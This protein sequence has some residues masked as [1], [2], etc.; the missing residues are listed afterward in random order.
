[1]SCL[2]SNFQ[3][4][5]EPLS[6]TCRNLVERC[7]PH[8]FGSTFS[9][10]IGREL[11]GPPASYFCCVYLR[12]LPLKYVETQKERQKQSPKQHF[13]GV[14][15]VC[16]R[17]CMVLA[18]TANNP[19]CSILSWENPQFQG[20][21]HRQCETETFWRPGGDQLQHTG[22]WT[23]LCIYKHISIIYIYII[24]IYCKATMKGS[25]YQNLWDILGILALSMYVWWAF[26][27]F[28]ESFNGKN[29]SPRENYEILHERTTQ[30]QL[31]ILRVIQV[32]IL[33]GIKQCKSIHII[34]VY[35][36]YIYIEIWCL[37]LEKSD[38]VWVGVLLLM[39]E[40]PNNQLGCM[41]NPV[42]N[43]R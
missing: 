18:L 17:E 27:D 14:L 33:E 30:A 43:G 26:E 2:T 12:R 15:A 8:N 7:F 10:S 3:T 9:P 19:V 41:I 35:N 24:L 38:I 1:M 40:I 4:L 25:L 34:Y 23:W 16:F 32:A 42:N 20:Q 6:L 5:A 31:V 21:S 37:C 22:K 29:P 13:S 36:I 39:E 28:L 11:E